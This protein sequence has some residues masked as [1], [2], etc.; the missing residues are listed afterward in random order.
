MAWFGQVGPSLIVGFSSRVPKYQC[1]IK[2]V[3]TIHNGEKGKKCQ[4]GWFGVA[5]E[6]VS[7]G[8]THGHFC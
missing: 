7:P 6:Y 1:L 3:S 2:S 5:L 4:H 8:V